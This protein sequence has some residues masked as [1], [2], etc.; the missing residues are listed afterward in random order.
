MGIPSW[1]LE[2]RP[3][4]SMQ[5]FF[6]RL[7][8]GPSTLEVSEREDV[9][10]VKARI[11]DREGV[12]VGMQRL[13]FGGKQL[14]DG[15]NLQDYS[16]GKDSTL[17]LVLRILGG[18]PKK[19]KKGGDENPAE[20]QENEIQNIFKLR[21]E[22]L[23]RELMLKKEEAVEA[24]HAKNELRERVKEYHDEFEREKMR[25]LD[26]TADMTRQYKA[27]HELFIHEINQLENQILDLHD[28]LK[29]SEMK[30][31][32]HRTETKKQ[33]EEK[34]KVIADQHNKMEQMAAEFGNMLEETLKKMTDRI[35]ISQKGYDEDEQEED[36]DEGEAVADEM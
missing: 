1:A 11:A 16:I 3:C 15:R 14:E 26:I 24:I 33:M 12:P 19:K 25:T 22:F 29:L 36:D 23:E 8:G 2:D 7:S 10:A 27:M 13:I 5:I 6:T 4:R 34:D 21:I 35:E 28:Q 32:R 31:E 17:H 30:L 18:A 20:L 9:A